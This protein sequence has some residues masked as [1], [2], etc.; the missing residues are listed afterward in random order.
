MSGQTDTAISKCAA[1][2]LR[3]AS[4]SIARVYDGRLDR[5]GLTTTQFSILRNLD[6]QDAPVALAALADEL[7]FER[8]SLHRALEPLRRDGLIAYSNGPGRAKRVAI[9]PRGIR[10]VAQATPHWMAAQEE[11]VSRFGRAAWNGLAA[12]LV[13]IVSVARDMPV[14]ED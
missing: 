3:R 4:R 5:I 11:F 6:G 8:T 14:T 2:T 7:V 1:G 10:K 9:T 13:E 12:Q